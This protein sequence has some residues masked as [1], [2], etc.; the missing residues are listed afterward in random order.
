[1]TRWTGTWLTGP[2]AQRDEPHGYRGERLGLPETGAG[3]VAS[4]GRKLGALLIDLVIAG[5]I[6]SFFVGARLMDTHAMQQQN[7]WGIVIWLVITVIGVGA[8]SFTPGMALL[9]LRVLRLD[10][11]RRVGLLRAIPRTIAV[12]ILV[13]AVI[14]DADNRGLHDKMVGTLVVNAR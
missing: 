1:V 3:S 9:R 13:P 8:F 7:Y 12:G 6:S 5:L 4:M 14:W 10:G 11:A 2:A